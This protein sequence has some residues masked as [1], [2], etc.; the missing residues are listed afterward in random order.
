MVTENC[1]SD[2]IK[3]KKNGQFGPNFET[4]DRDINMKRQKIYF[5]IYFTTQK[6]KVPFLLFL[7]FWKGEASYL[8]VLM[9]N[10]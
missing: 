5:N 3:E 10:F 8:A 2:R 9:S 4:F 7:F 6:I 1:C